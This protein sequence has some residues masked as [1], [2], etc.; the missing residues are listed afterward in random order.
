MGGD[1]GMV[2]RGDGRTGRG[3]RGRRAG[4]E[5]LGGVGSGGRPPTPGHQSAPSRGVV[6]ALQLRVH[7]PTTTGWQWGGGVVCRVVRPCT[8]TTHEPRKNCNSVIQLILPPLIPW[9]AGR[10]FSI[11]TP[12]LRHPD[13]VALCCSGPL[14]CP[15]PPRTSAAQR[16]A[17]PVGVGGSLLR[18]A[19]TAPWVVGCATPRRSGPAAGVPSGMPTRP[20]QRAFRSARGVMMGAGVAAAAA[21][22]ATAAA[23]GQGCCYWGLSAGWRGVLAGW[24]GVPAAWRR[25]LNGLHFRT[26]GGRQRRSSP[27]GAAAAGTTRDAA[28][29]R[30]AAGR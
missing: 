16:C 1:S 5:R 28:P 23:A 15:S 20:R 29:P 2:G 25:R 24:R 27:A 13:A 9:C 12:A 19:T 6:V 30:V 10:S 7:S 22:V 17:S 8:C 14:P 18:G 26:L 11:T 3:G 4:V 21:T